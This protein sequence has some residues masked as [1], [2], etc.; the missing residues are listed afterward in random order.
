M[1]ET[2]ISTLLDLIPDESCEE[3][4]HLIVSED[5]KS[6]VNDIISQ[7][8]PRDRRVIVSSFGL[9]GK[10]PMNLKEIGEVEDL[11]REMVRQIKMKVLEKL[12]E[13]LKNDTIR[14]YQ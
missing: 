14:S 12:K 3:A 8:K 5:L 9:D 6:E 13:R 10:S 4:D 7:L 2:G 11:S 1:G